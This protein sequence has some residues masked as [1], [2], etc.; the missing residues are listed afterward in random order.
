MSKYSETENNRRKQILTA[1]LDR[2]DA[3]TVIQDLDSARIKKTFPGN[4]GRYHIRDV[5][6]I[7]IDVEDRLSGIDEKESSFDL[8]FLTIINST[9][10]FVILV[11]L[12]SHSPF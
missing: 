4:S 9:I 7:I 5:N 10:P 3:V 2:M 6:K 1:E 11:I 8:I 12:A